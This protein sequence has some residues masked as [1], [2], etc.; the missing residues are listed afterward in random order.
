MCDMNAIDTHVSSVVLAQAT[1]SDFVTSDAGPA[2]IA[3]TIASIALS[4]GYLIF[5][6]AL[7]V[8]P[9]LGLAVWY[10]GR[11]HDTEGGQRL[12]QRH[13]ARPVRSK[14]SINEAYRN[15][16]EGAAMAADIEQGAYGQDVK[17]MQHKVYWFCGLWLLANI[18]AFGVLI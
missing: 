14:G 18:V 7:M 1:A 16:D 6:M 5:C 17:A 3:G 12:M 8:L 2:G 11:I 4:D 15:L 10:H 9:M 13:N